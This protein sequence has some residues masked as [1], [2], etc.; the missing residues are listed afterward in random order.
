MVSSVINPY[1]S[2]GSKQEQDVVEDLIIESMSFYGKPM[3]YIPRTLVSKD[4]ILHED[5]L[6]EFKGAYQI[7]MYIENV[8]AFEGQG[9]FMQKFGLMTEQSATF[10]VSRKRWQFLVGQ[11]GSTIIPSRPNE[12][13]LIY[14]PMTNGIFEIKFVNHLN[15]LYQLGK[16]Y[17]YKLQVELFQY[18]S[19]RLNTGNEEIDIFE[20]LKSFDTTINPDI[21]VPGD[22]G[23]NNKFKTERTPIV[24]TE[25]NPFGD[26]D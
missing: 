19:E 25:T 11:H 1:F 7:E 16:L 8:D 3:F 13:D 10:V 6:S 15:P 24:F 9:V 2:Q 23:N 4:D 12:G 17:V 14:F 26:P 21:D 18:A 20:T 5:R 22:Y